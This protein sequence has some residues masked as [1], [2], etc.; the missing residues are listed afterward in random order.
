MCK[1]LR[2]HNSIVMDFRDFDTGTSNNV[3][4]HL[5]VPCQPLVDV[6]LET[7]C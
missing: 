4:G 7:R 6:V 3:I 1:N 5:L 2:S